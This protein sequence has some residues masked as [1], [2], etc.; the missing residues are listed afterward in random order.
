MPGIINFLLTIDNT[1]NFTR[2]AGFMLLT[3]LRPCRSWQS[4]LIVSIFFLSNSEQPTPPVVETILF[5]KLLHNPSKW[6]FLC[7]NSPPQFCLLEVLQV[8]IYFFH[9]SFPYN[10]Y[11]HLGRFWFLVPFRR[12]FAR[13]G[14]VNYSQMERLNKQTY[15]VVDTE[16]VKDQFY[17]TKNKITRVNPVFADQLLFSLGAKLPWK[18]IRMFCDRKGRLAPCSFSIQ[19]LRAVF[20]KV[21]NIYSIITPDHWLCWRR[22]CNFL[23]LET[24]KIAAMARSD[25]LSQCVLKYNTSVQSEIL[26]LLSLKTLRFV[27][28]SWKTTSFVSI[29][30]KTITILS[31]CSQQTHL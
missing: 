3:Y 18:E 21:Y 10:F 27:P 16:S 12:G 29:P 14:I 5:P 4:T 31:H 6:S 8:F 17:L 13:N 1:T 9:S 24:T 28:G 30:T 15:K 22:R 11:C 19:M 26:Q 20:T 2:S 25:A 7:A 23:Q